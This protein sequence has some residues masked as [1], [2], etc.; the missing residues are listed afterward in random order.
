MEREFNRILCIQITANISESTYFTVK[1]LSGVLISLWNIL[2]KSVD[3]R[4]NSHL[5]G[6]LYGTEVLG[7][8]YPMTDAYLC[9]L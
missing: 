8:E 9:G 7:V 6:V 4:Y 3:S 5:A 1:S 2:L